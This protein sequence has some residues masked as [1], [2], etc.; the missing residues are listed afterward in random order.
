MFIAKCVQDG[1]RVDLPL[2]RHFFKLMCQRPGSR[3]GEGSHEP[4]MQSPAPS[5][6]PSPSPVL[7]P[8]QSDDPGSV[9]DNSAQE[10]N[11]YVV[12]L[13]PA[14]Q[15]QSHSQTALVSNQRTHSRSQQQLEDVISEDVISEGGGGGDAGMKETELLLEAEES[16]EE[17]LKDGKPKLATELQP[18]TGEVNSICRTVRR[19]NYY[20][21]R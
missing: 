7:L 12:D 8:Q 9:N 18:H 10:S 21:S 4:A 11:E 13:E 15:Q 19:N 14:Q 16:G 1:R 2:S 3:E 5:P 20:I 6:S 17:I